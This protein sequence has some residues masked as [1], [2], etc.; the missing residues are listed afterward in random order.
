[1]VF[2]LSIA[3]LFLFFDLMYFP[4]LTLASFGFEAS[5]GMIHWCPTRCAPSMRPS[6]HKVC[7][8]LAQMPH[9]SEICLIDT[10]S[11]VTLNIVHSQ[12]VAVYNKPFLF[13]SNKRTKSI[14]R[15]YKSRNGFCISNT[16][17]RPLTIS[18]LKRNRIRRPDYPLPAQKFSVIHQTRLSSQSYNPIIFIESR[19]SRHMLYCPSFL[20]FPSKK[21]IPDKLAPP[22]FRPTA[23]CLPSISSCTKGACLVKQHAQ[24][25]FSCQIQK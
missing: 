16:P 17:F 20:L 21:T 6:V 24:Y 13:Y 25:V 10:Y 9:F 22:F 11:T 18:K 15:S 2:C 4:L 5:A 7:T 23:D 3:S 14:Q 12:M 1:M 19:K 8:R